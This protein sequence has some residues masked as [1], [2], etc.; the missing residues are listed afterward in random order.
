LVRGF[1]S[2]SEY[3]LWIVATSFRGDE[4]QKVVISAPAF[5]RA[6]LFC[7]GTLVGVIDLLHHAPL[8]A[9]K[10]W[11]LLRRRNAAKGEP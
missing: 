7:K 6:T 11:R 5:R 3:G 8:I 10:R 2:A 9:K 4:I 1:I